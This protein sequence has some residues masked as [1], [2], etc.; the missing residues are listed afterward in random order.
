ML[1]KDLQS[2][3]LMLLEA[4]VLTRKSKPIFRLE[5]EELLYFKEVEEELIRAASFDHILNVLLYLKK[6]EFLNTPELA[7]QNQLLEEYLIVCM[8]MEAEKENT[9]QRKISTDNNPSLFD[10]ISK[11]ESPQF[12]QPM[13]SSQDTKASNQQPKRQRMT[14]EEKLQ[15]IKSI[16][17]YQIQKGG[18]ELGVLGSRHT[19]LVNE[20]NYQVPKRIRLILGVLDRTDLNSTEKLDE[21]KNIQTSALSYQSGI[22][23]NR[24][25][26]STNHFIINFNCNY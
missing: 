23:F 10:E 3:A 14:K 5:S 24:T 8:E 2:K 4:I 21:I 15:D 26:K 12:K 6:T 7:L 25:Q 20:R 16:I 11:T 19:V 13:T 18:F 17:L 9:E 22:L 1:F